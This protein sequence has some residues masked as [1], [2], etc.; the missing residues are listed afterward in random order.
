MRRK[1]ITAELTRLRFL[2]NRRGLYIMN[3]HIF[4]NHLSATAGK[5]RY[6]TMLLCATVLL[7][8]TAAGTADA[9]IS[10]FPYSL[11]QTC[12]K[13]TDYQYV[14]RNA[15]LPG[16]LRQLHT[17]RKRRAERNHRQKRLLCRQISQLVA[18]AVYA[19]TE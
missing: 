12:T 9:N 16:Q 3:T 13:R 7:L 11:E 15:D 14:Q 17:G 18:A 1:A 2:I 8:C 10:V 6:A 19:K 4:L 5:L